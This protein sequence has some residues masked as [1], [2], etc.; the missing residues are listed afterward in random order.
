[1]KKEK[2]ATFS[3][4]AKQVPKIKINKKV[5]SVEDAAFVKK[6]MT[7]GA[8]ILSIADLPKR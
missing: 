6:K 1:M 2:K 8:R 4:L 7:K 3:D 5:D